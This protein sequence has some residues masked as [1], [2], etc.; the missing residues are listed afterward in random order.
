MGRWW[1]C[2]L[3]ATAASG[4]LCS[5]NCSKEEDG[6]GTAPPAPSHAL[7]PFFLQDMT[8]GL[9]LSGDVFK[10]CAIDTIWYISGAQGGSYMVHHKPIEEE[11]VE[12][13]GHTLCLERKSCDAVDGSGL[14]QGSCE[15]C[16]A[17]GWSMIAGDT[18]SGYVMSSNDHTMCLARVGSNALDMMQWSSPTRSLE[19]K[20]FGT[21]VTLLL[22]S[23]CS[24]EG[25]TP[26]ALLSLQ[27]TSRED[28][29]AMSKPGVRMITAASDGHRREVKKWLEEGVDVNSQDW[30]QLTPL[31]AAAS[32]GHLDVVK[33]LV[34]KG[35][36]VNASDKDAITALMEAAIMDHQS[37]VKYLLKEGAE[38]DATTTS[39]V[40]ALWLAAGEGR[41]EEVS[42]L[43]SKK[44]DVNVSRSDGISVVMAAS[45]GGH[46]EVVRLLVEEGADIHQ[47]DQD[48]LTA[49]MNAA[50]IGSVDIVGYL[51]DKGAD[52]NV[53]SHT[54]FTPLILGAAG[55]HLAVIKRLVA[56][57]AELNKPHPDSVNSLMYAAAG[58]HLE[59]VQ[60]LIDQGSEPN[61]LHAHGGSALMEASTSGNPQVVQLLLDKGAKVNVRD[62][63]GVTS[64]MS[65]AS[66][67][68]LEV[69]KILLANGAEVDEVAYSGGGSLMFAASAGY[70]DVARVLLEHGAKV[71]NQVKATQE[72][73]DAVLAA[74]DEGNDKV[75]WRPHR[76]GVTILMLAALGGH[77]DMVKLLLEAGADVTAQDEAGTT[78]LLNAIKGNYGD[79]ATVLVQ[80]GANPNDVYVD[81]E[82]NRHNLLMDAIIV[83]NAE[84]AA[85]LVKAGAD[86][87][88]TDEQGV[89]TLVQAAHRNMTSIAKLLLEE[90]VDAS[91]ASLEGI[92]ALIA[93]ASEG[94]TEIVR[95]LLEEAHSDPDVCDKDGTSALMA[96]SVRG[97]KDVVELL[98]AHNANVN[99]QNNYGHRYP[100]QCCSPYSLNA[101]VPPLLYLASLQQCSCSPLSC[102]LSPAPCTLDTMADHRC[103]CFL[104][105]QHHVQSL[106]LDDTSFSPSQLSSNLSSHHLPGRWR[107]HLALLHLATVRR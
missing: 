3:T 31:I 92:T 10:R 56:K 98:I 17:G 97:H 107:H 96:A 83:E 21:L 94:H 6:A 19:D 44:A 82:G 13:E 84:F 35:A 99:A 75:S 50:E 4:L 87:S 38:V 11:A 9:C 26:P 104:S 27:F 78:A 20:A 30:D 25:G 79:V 81:E 32:A 76:D 54:G 86:L 51:L 101:L 41:R 43:L 69:C 90:G 34:S 65:A 45:V 36:D 95:L 33:L 22:P 70:T 2:A 102:A 47:T 42:L 74:I 68:H 73:K 1:R 91:Q 8:D 12:E 18:E 67:G 77:L 62:M 24:G 28:I 100:S 55:G 46:Y 29:A 52:P 66:Q 61:Q 57:G 15:A 58:A 39:G 5:G 80:A 85:L 23:F 103:V 88:V 71:N 7:S 59:V 89:T 60:Y 93:A 106:L 40:T 72:Y 105:R 64:L 63:D 16:G 49:L 48:G 37:V 53:M 14:R